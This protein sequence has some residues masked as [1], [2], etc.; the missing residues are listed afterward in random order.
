MQVHVDLVPPYDVRLQVEHSSASRYERAELTIRV[1]LEAGRPLDR[2]DIRE[3]LW[4]RGTIAITARCAG[5]PF[6]AVA[7]RA[8]PPSDP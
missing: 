5:G 4:Q 7:V 1:P 6:V 8:E 3:S 2:D